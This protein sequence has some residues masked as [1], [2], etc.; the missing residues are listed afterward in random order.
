MKFGLD[1]D[2]TTDKDVPLWRAFAADAKSRGHEVYIVTMRYPSERMKP[3]SPIT[4]DWDDLVAGIHFTSR[5]AKKPFMEALGIEIDVWIDDHPKTV[6]ENAKEAFGMETPEGV[7]ISNLKE[8]IWH[9]VD[10]I[11]AD[12]KEF[13]G[14][15]SRIAGDIKFCM[16]YS[17]FHKTPLPEGASKLDFMTRWDQFKE[18]TMDQYVLPS[19]RQATIIQWPEGLKWKE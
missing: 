19:K 4:V 9:S 3:K 8:V 1:W 16:L 14:I 5:K 6:N 10:A 18:A 2:G 12:I 15:D 7:V 17:E 11:N 13:E